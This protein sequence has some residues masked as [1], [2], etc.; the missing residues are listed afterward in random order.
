MCRLP[1]LVIGKKAA[2]KIESV[3]RYNFKYPTRM[4]RSRLN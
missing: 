2:K 3:R 4:A 1:S